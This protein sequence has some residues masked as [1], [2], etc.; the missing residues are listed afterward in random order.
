MGDGLTVYAGEP[1][2][3]GAIRVSRP[4]LV[5]RIWPRVSSATLAI[6]GR[7]I[8][9]RYDPASRAVVGQPSAPLAP[10]KHRVR[11]TVGFD[12]GRSTE[13]VWSV[14]ILPG[15][16]SEPTT[17]TT[18]A[19]RASLAL[20]QG[21]RRSLG[22]GELVLDGALQSAARAHAEYLLRNGRGGH[23]EER[24]RPGFLGRTP[25]E[26]ARSF[27]ATDDIL[28]EDVAV[29]TRAGNSGG[30]ST[31]EAVIGLFDAPYHRLPF[32][33]PA[34]Q[35]IGVA[36]GERLSGG[37]TTGAT[38]LLFSGTDSPERPPRTML[39]PRDGQAGVPTHW[40]DSETPD[41]LRLHEGARPPVGFPML[42]AHFPRRP[43]AGPSLPLRCDGATLVGPDGRKVPLL[44]NA[45]PYDAELG[46]QAVLLIPRDPLLPDSV[47]RATVLAR[48]GAGQPI[49]RTWKFRTAR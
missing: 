24:G 10:G 5:W 22:L 45:P 39:S 36:H 44:V 16:V 31:D 43:D 29:L 14:T 12:G 6:D 19:E 18:G 2:P 32:L 37:T 38:V 34:L 9:S 49:S 1:Q 42:F 13:R 33:N 4:R 3:Q 23:L 21:I 46:G 25:A 30:S 20:I 15:S 41:P 28:V 47:Y 11:C 48:N 27:G 7:E 35:K 26:R 40:L 8:D 17:A